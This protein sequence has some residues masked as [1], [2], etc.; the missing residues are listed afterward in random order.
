MF[1]QNNILQPTLPDPDSYPPLHNQSQNVH[2]DKFIIKILFGFSF[3]FES[4]RIRVRNLQ[5]VF[6]VSEVSIMK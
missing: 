3:R 2:D 6:V 5:I 4:K 1:Q